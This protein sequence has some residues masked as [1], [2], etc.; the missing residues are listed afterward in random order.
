MTN[1]P[2]ELWKRFTTG[3]EVN[4]PEQSSVFKLRVGGNWNAAV[5]MKHKL[6]NYGTYIWGAEISGL[7]SKNN[8]K[9]GVQID[10]NL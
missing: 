10:L 5:S 1:P 3:F 2:S 9:F 7:G 6:G 8:V 4:L